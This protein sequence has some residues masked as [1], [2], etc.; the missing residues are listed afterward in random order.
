MFPCETTFAVAAAHGAF[1]VTV[2]PRP[3]RTRLLVWGG[4]F[5]VAALGFGVAAWTSQ[6][7]IWSSL[8]ELLNGGS[9]FYVAE[10]MGIRDPRRALMDVAV[11]LLAWA[12]VLTPAWFAAGPRSHWTRALAWG[13]LLA[14]PAFVLER[15]FFRSAPLLLSAGV[16]WIASAGW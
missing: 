8:F 11:S 16:A 13:A 9:R 2:L 4:G 7:R 15:A 1:L 10:S 14:I 12:M 5:A 3:G 6:G